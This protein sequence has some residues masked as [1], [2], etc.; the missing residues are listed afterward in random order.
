MGLC[1]IS[2]RQFVSSQQSAG[3]KDWEL[4]IRS[5]LHQFTWLLLGV[6]EA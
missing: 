1:S 2:T 6:Q 5:I 3:A 4:V